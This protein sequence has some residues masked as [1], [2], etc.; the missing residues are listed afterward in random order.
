MNL[1]I[2][3]F[4]RN[5]TWVTLLSVL[6]LSLCL[7]FLYA[8]V[9]DFISFLPIYKTLSVLLTSPIF[10]LTVIL[11]TGFLAVLDLEYLVLQKEIQP[12]IYHMLRSVSEGDRGFCEPESRR[13]MLEKVVGPVKDAL[14]K[15]D[16]TG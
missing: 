10:F 12:P 4:T 9:V 8:V 7:F 13:S 14:F 15:Y 6:G 2:V 11:V 5:F 1:K 16:E 3:L